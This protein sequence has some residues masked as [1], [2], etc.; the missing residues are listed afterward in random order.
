MDPRFI[1][2]RAQVE[3]GVLKITG[4]RPME[5]AMMTDHNMPVHYAGD[6]QQRELTPP[7]DPEDD[8]QTSQNRRSASN[9]VEASDEDGP[10][11]RG[12]Y[13]KA[14]TTKHP[15][16]RWV[17]RGQGRYLPANAVVKEEND[18]PPRTTRHSAPDSARPKRNSS[19]IAS[20]EPATKLLRSH[21]SHPNTTTPSKSQNGRSQ[22]SSEA[23]AN[24]KLRHRN[25]ETETPSASEL[26]SARLARRAKVFPS[27]E[28]SLS[29]PQSDGSADEDEEMDEVPD[30]TYRI[31]YVNAH[32]GE[33][34]YHTGNG[35]WKR[36]TKPSASG[37]TTK[38][39][40]S[41]RITIKAQSEMS[42]APDPNRTY[43]TTELEALHGYEYHHCGNG[44]YK[45]GPGPSRRHSKLTEEE[46]EDE[47]GNN[48]INGTVAKEWMLTYQK[49]HPEVDFV[50]R[51]NGRYMRKDAV[52]LADGDIPNIKREKTFDK[53]YV[54][55]HPGEEFHHTGYGRYRRGPRPTGPQP[56]RLSVSSRRTTRDFTQN[57]D[58]G[59]VDEEEDV[60]E[61]QETD[62][63]VNKDYVLRH[64]SQ[65]FHHRGQGRYAR[66]PKQVATRSESSEAVDESL[67]D[68]SYV[69][70][71]PDQL[72][73]HRGQGRWAR[74]PPP[75]GSTA[76]VAV[77][78]AGSE[79]ILAEREADKKLNKKASSTP[80]VAPR[81]EPQ[82]PSSTA[83]VLRVDGPEKWPD[84]TWHYR[85][86]GKW[87]Q[88]TKDEVE[89]LLN[90]PKPANKGRAKSKAQDD[91]P[92]AQL[93]RE[94][95]EA[96]QAAQR[97]RMDEM[98]DHEEPTKLD[99]P[100]P[101]P[102]MRRKRSNL[103]TQEETA[104]TKH[105]SKTA[106]PKPQKL[107]PEEDVLGDEDFPSLYLD[108]WPDPDPQ[109]P[110][111]KAAH[112]LRRDYK[113][114]ASA[115]DFIKALT[116]HDPAVRSTGNL[117]ELA[118]HAQQALKDLQ[119]EYLALDKITAPH[120]RIPRKPAKGGRL[121][122]E[123]AVFE[124]RK[125]AD[126]Y[127]YTFD[128]RRIGFQDPGAQKI[129]RD[130]EGREL[131]KRRIRSGGGF[132]TENVAAA[133]LGDED[134][135]A[136]ARGRRVK[137]VM[138]F[139]GV[140][141]QPKRRRNVN[142][143]MGSLVP[144]AGDTGANMTPDP[145][146]ATTAGEG[147]V[148]PNGYRV[149]TSGR[150]AN[151][152][153][154]RIRELRGDSVGSARSTGAATGEGTPAKEG[155]PSKEATPGPH[156]KGRPPGSKNL[157]KRKDAGIPK[158]PKKKPQVVDSIEAPSDGQALATTNA[159]TPTMDAPAA[160]DGAQTEEGNIPTTDSQ[161]D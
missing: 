75:P 45:L 125:E 3:N 25:H 5:F 147:Q 70:N 24:Y 59:D 64:P 105:S 115:D 133:F 8:A 106:T 65:E 51:G 49:R 153:P 44:Y 16:I 103:P 110:D 29:I 11:E 120:A 139:D 137:P 36:G 21:S 17:H 27:V 85:G 69:D 104:A 132:D 46:S 155:S 84:L 22:L 72:F 114:L 158:G 152:V 141:A 145:T 88:S 102:K 87:C 60:D 83:L 138:R 30:Q 118:A 53:A 109:E 13:S 89:A 93:E 2:R 154:K 144:P 92:H 81:D 37:P 157:H 7:E 101:K 55:A 43:H 160:S 135:Y 100:A 95:E 94:A 90:G 159:V 40:D 62:G 149:P 86:G 124:D 12:T 78:G 20:S 151:H 128:P 58:D 126:L 39:R 130:A 136:S 4:I 76:K 56:G 99:A 143:T 74:G 66:G 31:D 34:F 156:R 113:P 112:V 68:R 71:H 108:K 91:S 127:D 107:A 42:D 129:V 63:L 96:E 38:R 123:P 61:D 146:A 32:P 48:G 41:S 119:D 79:T 77:R 54:E 1:R 117:M 161:A 142:A 134:K 122:V 47:D 116:K 150:W 98:E 111:D 80:S 131:R 9:A 67:V 140:V 52:T 6:Q 14:Y 28:D 18:F 97:R 23:Q 57:D 121:P 35:W 10:N 50:H 15:E 33:S 73:H 26:R 19:A 82:P 148:L